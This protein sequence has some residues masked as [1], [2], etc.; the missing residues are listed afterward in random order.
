MGFIMKERQGEEAMGKYREERNC[1]SRVVNDGEEQREIMVEA[2][3]SD[4]ELDEQ[5]GEDR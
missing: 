5:E 2:V 4:G 3:K 1:L